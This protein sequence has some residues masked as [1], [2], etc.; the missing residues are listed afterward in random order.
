[1]AGTRI[2]SPQ[3]AAEPAVREV[4]IAVCLGSDER[5]CGV[6]GWRGAFHLG[7]A[8]KVED[9]LLLLRV[10][11]SHCYDRAESYVL[12]GILNIG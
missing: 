7:F 2:L 12:N 9:R 8:C 4:I 6:E 10:G 3:L 5:G 1:M 11:L